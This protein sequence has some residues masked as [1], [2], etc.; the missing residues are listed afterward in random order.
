M[1]NQLT[2]AIPTTAYVYTYLSIS[3][4][5]EIFM[6]L[7]SYIYFYFVIVFIRH[8][9]RGNIRGNCNKSVFF[10]CSVVH[11]IYNIKFLISY[12]FV[13]FF[14]LNFGDIHKMRVFVG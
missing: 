10:L 2:Y 7:K 4:D 3:I 11:I 12:Y 9:A 6:S 13:S 14:N 5:P 8:D 1:S